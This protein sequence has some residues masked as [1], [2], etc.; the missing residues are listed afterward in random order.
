MRLAPFEATEG[1]RLDPRRVG[2]LQSAIS[3]VAAR[4]RKGRQR[5]QAV[6]DLCHASSTGLNPETSWRMRLVRPGNLEYQVTIGH[7]I[8][9]D[10]Q[11]MVD[12]KR[13]EALIVRNLE[14][15]ATIA[16]GLDL[17]GPALVSISLDGV[18]DC[19][20]VRRAARRKTSAAAGSYFTNGEAGRYER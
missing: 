18:E 19:R 6:V 20:T 8:D 2:E 7:R 16:N 13:L 9:D 10:P 3:A 12:R 15:M 14:R 17:A 1:R 5:R 4:A 11:I